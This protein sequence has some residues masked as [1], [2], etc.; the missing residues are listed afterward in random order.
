MTN[1]IF[2]P[3]NHWPVHVSN[4]SLYETS[5][6]LYYHMHTSLMQPA[7][8]YSPQ[9]QRIQREVGTEG[10]VVGAV[11]RQRPSSAQGHR[12]SIETCV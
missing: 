12:D 7:Y 5:Q 6:P 4:L 10:S 3:T 11:T 9:V 8:Y 1:P 2:Q